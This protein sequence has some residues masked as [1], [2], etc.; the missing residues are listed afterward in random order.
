M[1]SGNNLDHD[2]AL[3]LAPDTDIAP[4]PDGT[5]TLDV[6]RS[7]LRFRAVAWRL[8]PV[9]GTIRPTSGTVS[10]LR[11]SLSAAGTA[12]A[13]SINT[14]IGVRDWHLR[15]SHY[16]NAKMFPAIQLSVERCRRESGE[17]QATLEVRG[18]PISLPLTLT[19]IE[20]HD[21]GGL[22]VK[23]S[24]RFDRT[25][26]GMLAPVFGVSRMIDIDLTIVATRSEP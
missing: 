21:G 12:D 20:A 17:A 2:P 18:Q 16:L 14:G 9:R 7:E 10:I 11:N 6:H 4:L 26:V 3:S 15:H 8:M 23:A 13:T 5:Y 25:G 1:S 19:A 24:G 22:R